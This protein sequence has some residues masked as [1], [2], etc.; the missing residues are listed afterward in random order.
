MS[1]VFLE[2]VFFGVCIFWVED[3]SFRL[4]GLILRYLIFLCLFWIGRKV[5]LKG[6]FGRINMLG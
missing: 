3:F 2:V 1:R 4:F 6:E 5:S